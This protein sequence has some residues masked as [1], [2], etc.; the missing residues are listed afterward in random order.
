[1]YAI[2]GLSALRLGNRVGVG[3]RASAAPKTYARVTRMQLADMGSKGLIGVVSM[4][5]R[6]PNL[7]ASLIRR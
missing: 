4:A 5:A 3:E 6:L 1:M 2:V 7:K